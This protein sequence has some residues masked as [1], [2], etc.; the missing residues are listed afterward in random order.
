LHAGNEP[1]PR[2]LPRLADPSQLARAS[3]EFRRDEPSEIRLLVKQSPG[4]WLVLTDT[5]M[6][7]WH[8][9][10]DG[11]DR[12]WHRADLCFR[13]LWVPPG[14]HEVRF[15]YDATPF[16]RGLWLTAGAL[17]TMLVLMLWWTGHREAT[18]SDLVQAETAG[19]GAGTEV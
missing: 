10:I 6:S 16:H 4:A 14:E 3:V 1:L 9:S 5:A 2:P 11:A 8:A 19:T 12:P 13:A 17:A 7:H 18:G 15:S